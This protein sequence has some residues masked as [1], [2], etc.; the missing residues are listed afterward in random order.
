MTVITESDESFRSF[1]PVHKPFLNILFFG[2]SGAGKSS[3]I[4]NLLTSPDGKKKVEKQAKPRTYEQEQMTRNFQSYKL[5]PYPIKL[6]DCWGWKDGTNYK[7]GEFHKM[8][9][10]ALQEGFEMDSVNFGNSTS[11]KN[12]IDALVIVIDGPRAIN[13]EDNFFEKLRSFISFAQENDI[14]IAF[15]IT[16]V[17]KLTDLDKVRTMDNKTARKQMEQNSEY[18]A[19]RTRIKKIFS[20]DKI[21]VFP[22]LNFESEETYKDDLVIET[23]VAILDFITSSIRERAA[24]SVGQDWKEL[25]IFAGEHEVVFQYAYH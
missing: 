18:K 24:S 13:E 8:L 9:E 2:P 21:C 17:D 14:V 4:N 6:F 16:K 19:I 25:D 11:K 22:V 12:G 7:N 3:L 15:A 10:G 1:K 5:A 23:G 20:D